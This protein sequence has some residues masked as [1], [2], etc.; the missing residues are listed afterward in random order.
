MKFTEVITEEQ[1]QEIELRCNNAQQG[2]WTAYIEGR[3]HESG[4]DFIMTGDYDN[5]GQ[6]I[7][8][9][10]ATDADYDFIANAKQ[11]IPIL[12]EAIRYLK[13]KISTEYL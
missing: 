1:L 5:R 6:D 9:I 3:D 11:D 12:I 10:G 8:M 13:A 2:P 4:N 7:E